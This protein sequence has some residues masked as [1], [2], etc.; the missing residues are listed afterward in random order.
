MMKLIKNNTDET[1][2][3]IRDLN[4]A[5]GSGELRKQI[6]FDL[7]LKIQRGE[8]VIMTGPSGC[9]KTTLLPLVRVLLRP[10]LLPPG[11]HSR[12]RILCRDQAQCCFLKRRPYKLYLST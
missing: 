12:S 9:G 2:V 1:I 7:T 5:Y 4:F 3:N 11:C 8:I 6:L 10:F